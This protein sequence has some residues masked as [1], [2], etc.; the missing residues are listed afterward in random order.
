MA[1]DLASGELPGLRQK[2]YQEQLYEAGNQGLNQF[3][4]RALERGQK[5]LENRMSAAGVFGSGATVQAM[6]DL[7]GNLGAAQAR[8]MAGLAGQA[9]DARIGRLGLAGDLAGQ[10][11]RMFEQR[12]RYGI[13]D[14]MG[15]AGSQAGIFSSF[16][17]RSADE[18]RELRE[19]VI[20]NLLA[21]GGIDRAG[22]E[23]QAEE[24]MQSLGIF[25]T[26]LGNRAPTSSRAA[27]TTPNYLDPFRKT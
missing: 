12:E 3:Y 6:A 8:D 24:L 18:Q 22:A 25:A 11:Q 21:Q 7:Q 4:G 20:N 10:G 9:D 23:Q 16:A 1:E 26:A 17:N 19:N 27:P 15:L 2:G 5:D 13:N 14:A